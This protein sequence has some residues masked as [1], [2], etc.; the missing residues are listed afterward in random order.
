MFCKIAAMK[1]PAA[2][3]LLALALAGCSE[4]PG[5]P[6]RDTAIRLNLRFL[7]PGERSAFPGTEE[8]TASLGK[9]ARLVE[10]QVLLLT[11]EALTA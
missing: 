4:Q 5:Q 1:S 11:R 2:L 9:S 10:D 6:G 8:E 7:P 3:I